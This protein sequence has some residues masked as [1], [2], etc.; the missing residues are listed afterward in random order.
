MSVRPYFDEE[1]FFDV[2]EQVKVRALI[3]LSTSAEKPPVIVL[4]HGAGMSAFSWALTAQILKSS[5][6]VISLEFRAHGK[7]GGS[8]EDLSTQTLVADA[9]RCIEQLSLA[10]AY[11]IGHSLGGSIAMR[12]AAELRTSRPG[13][14]K[15]LCVVDMVEGTAVA[16]LQNMPEY[17][18]NRPLRF[19]DASHAVKWFTTWGGM[20]QQQ[21]PALTVPQL[22][23]PTGEWITN[24]AATKAHWNGWFDGCSAVFLSIPVPK[25]LLVTGTDILDKA[26]TIA[27]MQG[28]FQ[29]V[30]IGGVGHYMMEDAPRDVAQKLSEWVL[31]IEKVNNVLKTKGKQ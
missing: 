28:K 11:L 9:L 30:I 20:K 27:Q 2:A 17:L 10:E 24:L 16:A 8:E 5:F 18:R 13:F 19:D 4:F 31:H 25:L 12:V 3:G 21:S 29:M 26:L 1:Y 23:R 22:L 14:V 6:R 7:S 15:G